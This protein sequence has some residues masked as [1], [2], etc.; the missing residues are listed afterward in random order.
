[1]T[2]EKK[3]GYL[4]I[5]LVIVGLIFLIGLSILT[6]IWPSAWMWEPRQS[7]Y[8]QMIL[9]VYAT[10]GIFLLIASRDPLSHRSLIWFTIWSSIVHGGIMLV[11]AIVDETERAHLI[12]DVPGL[13]II[14]LV[15]WYLMPKGSHSKET[16]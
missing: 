11:Q 8:E 2:E 13:I 10:L 3:L 1:M 16:S 15:L 12:G 9:G 7:E 6:R 5:V 4:K 14:A